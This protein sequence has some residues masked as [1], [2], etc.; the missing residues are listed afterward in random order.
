MGC[1]TGPDR[2]GYGGC[3]KGLMLKN[4]EQFSET[5][6]HEGICMIVLLINKHLLVSEGTHVLMHQLSVTPPASL[7]N[8]NRSV[9]SL[10]ELKSSLC[11]LNSLYL[12]TELKQLI[13]RW[14]TSVQEYNVEEEL[15]LLWCS[16]LD[17]G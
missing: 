9:I 15:G 7:L 2:F 1:G 13:F 12:S 8:R 10:S 5:K 6:G 14:L 17:L 16:Q 4:K 11:Q 3:A